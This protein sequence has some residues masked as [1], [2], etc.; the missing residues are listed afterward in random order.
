MVWVVLGFYSTTLDINY[1]TDWLWAFEGVIHAKDEFDNEMEAD[2]KWESGLKELADAIKDK[3]EECKDAVAN[4]VDWMKDWVLR[5]ISKNMESAIE[6]FMLTNIDAL[7]SDLKFVELAIT[8]IENQPSIANIITTIWELKW[9]TLEIFKISTSIIYMD[10]L[11]IYSV[12]FIT[13]FI[14]SIQDVKDCYVKAAENVANE[15]EN[16][17]SRDQRWGLAIILFSSLLYPTGLGVKVGGT[18]GT[19]FTGGVTVEVTLGGLIMQLIAAALTIWGVLIIEN[20]APSPQ[21][22]WEEQEGV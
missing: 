3:W 22:I 4:A 1:V 12:P 11:F 10:S 6:I 21:E 5:Q 17:L 19:I 13:S 14:I 15:D 7:L 9:I 18:I 20:I 16:E 8:I 2:Q